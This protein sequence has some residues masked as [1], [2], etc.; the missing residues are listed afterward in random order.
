MSKST[1]PMLLVGG[2]TIVNDSVFNGQPINWRVPVAT[3]FAAGILSLVEH[4]LPEI[5]VGIAW[6]A[7][8]TVMLTRLPGQPRS[9]VE[10]FQRWW[11]Q[12]R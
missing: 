5:A 12:E 10:N 6:I 2:I 3:A 1:G 4:P 8:A 7:V 11:N 9:P